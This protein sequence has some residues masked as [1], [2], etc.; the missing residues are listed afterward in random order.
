MPGGTVSNTTG[1]IVIS[2]DTLDLTRARLRGEGEIIVNTPHL[3]S[4][5]EAV[6]DVEKLSYN[7][8]STN[9]TIRIQNL[10]PASGVVHRLRGP[11][12]VYSTLWQ[13]VAVAT[14]GPNYIF[15]NIP[16][17][18]PCATNPTVIGTN[19][20]VLLQTN[21]QVAIQVYYQVLMVDASKLTTD[22][23]VNVYDLTVHSPNTVMNDQMTVLQTLLIDGQS[24]TLNGGITIPGA[25]PVNPLTPLVAPPQI[26]LFD[27]KSVNAPRL[28]S[29]HEQWHTQHFQR[30]PFRR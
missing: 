13:N 26:P 4:S 12:S 29:L 5:S 28:L 7:L 14:L 19:I 21:V 30:G 22:L 10:V 20:Q 24:F 16:V 18:S 6:F 15:T 8:A 2:A 25:F 17:M 1:R 3:V 23:P 11:V 27:W 9:G